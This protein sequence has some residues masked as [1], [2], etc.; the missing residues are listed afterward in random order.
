MTAVSNCMLY[1]RSHESVM[2]FVSRIMALLGDLYDDN[3]ISVTRIGDS[4]MYNGLKVTLNRVHIGNFI[5]RMRRKGLERIVIRKD[6]TSSEILNLIAHISSKDKIAFSSEHINVGILEVKG[7][8]EHKL[9]GDELREHDIERYR[10]IYQNAGKAEGLDIMG[11]EDIVIDF[12][13]SL[14]REANVLRVASPIKSFSNYTF[15]HS[16]NVSI[17]SIF[18]AQTI[19]LKDDMLKD[20]GVAALL[21]DIGKIFI[22]GEVLEKKSKLTD[23]EWEI[24][25]Q[26]PILGAKYLS[27]L[28]EIPKFSVIA[29]F[30]HHLKFNGKGYPETKHRGNKQHLV[31]QIVAIADVFDALR[32]NRPYHKGMDTKIIIGILNESAGTDFNPDLIESFTKNIENLQD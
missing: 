7:T 14:H 12:I 24:M 9:E 22:P 25:R 11:L 2:K 3:R 16:T 20:I 19:G 21:H 1:S 15:T 26:H 29:A 6:V 23:S 4:L 17:I 27:L 5:N 28:N 8:S 30:E 32:A 10:E 13:T 18:I 31:S